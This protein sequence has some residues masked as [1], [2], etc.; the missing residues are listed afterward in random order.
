[1]P[2]VLNEGF[3]I[4]VS[5]VVA[6]DLLVEWLELLLDLILSSGDD[7][8]VLGVTDVGGVQDEQDLCFSSAIACGIFDLENGVSIS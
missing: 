3:I 7:E 1:M 6:L 4:E 8:L 5:P 2:E